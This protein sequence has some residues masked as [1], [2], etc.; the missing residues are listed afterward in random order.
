[1][2][3]KKTALCDEIIQACRAELCDLFPHLDGAFDGLRWRETDQRG[4]PY[5]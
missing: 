2:D 1:M 4:F 3:E 5:S